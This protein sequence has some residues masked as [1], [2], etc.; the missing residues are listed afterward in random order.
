MQQESVPI[1]QLWMTI[2]LCSGVP[3]TLIKHVQLL[4]TPFV[5]Y[6]FKICKKKKK[7]YWQQQRWCFICF[8][9]QR[10]PLV[11]RRKTNGS[12]TLIEKQIV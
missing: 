10:C 9:K 4:Q 1:C 11:V 3:E 8:F 12:L 5:K 7:P 2:L 6:N